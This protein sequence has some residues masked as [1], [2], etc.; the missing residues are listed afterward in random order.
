MYKLWFD[1]VIVE[2]DLC[3]KCGVGFVFD[4]VY[5][6]LC[7]V[8]FGWCFYGD[9][10]GEGVDFDVLCVEYIVFEIGIELMLDVFIFE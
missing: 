10:Q 7:Y 5:V 6:D 3:V 1:V 4:G 8:G 2:M 9:E